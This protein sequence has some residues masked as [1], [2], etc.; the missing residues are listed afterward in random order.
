MGRAEK[1]YL[2]ENRCCLC[3]E[4]SK[5]SD[6]KVRDR[7]RLTGKQRAAAHQ[8]CNLKAISCFW[9]IV[10]FLSTRIFRRKSFPIP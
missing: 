4:K 6:T 1:R 7:C 2:R 9:I 10:L 8:P 3:D 5:P